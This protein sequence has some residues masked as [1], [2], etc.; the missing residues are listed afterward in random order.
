M[1]SFANAFGRP[2]TFVD[3]DRRLA[4]AVRKLRDALRDS[5]EKPNFVETVGRRGHRFVGQLESTD[6][7]SADSRA[8]VGETQPPSS[9]PAEQ[10]EPPK[11]T[12]PGQTRSRFLGLI[13][14]SSAVLVI[15]LVVVALPKLLIAGHLFHCATV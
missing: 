1:R 2:D 9:P 13:L 7:P 6:L 5:A 11:P 15:L 4:V 8:G 3:F 12:P 14:L 10:E